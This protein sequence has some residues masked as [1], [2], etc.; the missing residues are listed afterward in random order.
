MF[1]I[2]PVARDEILEDVIIDHDTEQHHNSEEENSVAE[3]ETGQK[4]RKRN[5]TIPVQNVR[6]KSLNPSQWVKAKLKEAV[7]FGLAYVNSSGKN[8]PAKKLKNPCS[9]KK[10]C[11]LKVTEDQRQALFEKFYKLGRK[12]LQWFMIGKLVT[13]KPVERRRTVVIEDED[14]YR[15]FTYE[16]HLS[17]L[18][19]KLI[20]V[21]RTMFLNTFAIS[22]K[23]VVT[24]M[25][26]N[27]PDKRG[28]HNANRVRLA[29]EL[30]DSVRVHIKSFPVIPSHYCRADSRKNYLDERLSVAA[31]HRLYLQTRVAPGEQIAGEIQYLKHTANLRQ[32]RDIFNRLFNIGFFKPKKDQCA[33]CVEFDGLSEDQKTEEKQRAWE[34]HRANKEKVR[35]LRRADKEFSRSEQGK[36]TKVITVDL[37][38]VLYCPKSEVG[39][40]F[41]KRK[42]SV[43]NFTVFDCTLKS[44]TCY[45]WDQTTGHRGSNEMTSFVVDTITTEAGNGIK[46][47]YVYS[48]SCYGQVKNQFLFS[49]YYWISIKL[50]VKI[51]HRYLVKGHTQME[52]DSVHACIERK[53]KKK[54]V[55]TPQE[56]YT[57]I[58][59]AKVKKPHYNV[60]EISQEDIYS[61]KN[62]AEEFRWAKVPISKVCEVVL[63]PASPG[64]VF[65]RVNFDD[66]PT[67]VDIL[68]PRKGRPINWK[69]YTPPI[70][71]VEK[72]P[73]KPKLVEDLKWY[74]KKNLIPADFSEFYE[75]LVAEP[76][77]DEEEEDDMPMEVEGAPNGDVEIFDEDGDNSDI[78]DDPDENEESEDDSADDDKSVDSNMYD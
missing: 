42:L 68:K 67:E 39:E 20:P 10:R 23:V 35:G 64:K 13:K 78:A 38:K 50:Q 2:Q 51:V 32:Y 58:K 7:N 53:T 60:K 4:K 72:I 57:E 45:C 56:W 44:A 29:L 74:L 59:A 33:F 46:I 76:V 62:I 54:V 27:S 26:K 66:A 1:V 17:D 15:N 12:D 49:A 25:G 75:R 24:A 16:Y 69:T 14:S 19:G 55:F 36:D 77:D 21:C 48:D 71:Y 28:K 73:L 41:Y 70:A 9:C 6:K 22:I 40:F 52:C 3:V 8:I 5:N 47:V 63:D 37:Q 11:Y 65:Y 34:E 61:F 18:M 30:V 43:Y 31:M